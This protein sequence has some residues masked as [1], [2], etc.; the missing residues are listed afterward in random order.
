MYMKY[1]E[2]ENAVYAKNEIA[3]TTTEKLQ[4][5]FLGL[6][7]I[8]I[9]YNKVASNPSSTKTTGMQTRS[10]QIVYNV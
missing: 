1:K 10:E 2:T 3:E 9:L 8:Y 6:L 4:L 7:N 5:K